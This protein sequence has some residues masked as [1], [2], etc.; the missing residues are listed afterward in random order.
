MSDEYLLQDETHNDADEQEILLDVR[1]LQVHFPIRDGLFRRQVGAIRAVDDVSFAVARGETVALV[2][3]SGAGKTLIGRTIVQLTKPT[4]GEIRFQGRNI[5]QLN[6]AGLRALRRQVQIIFQDPYRSLNPRMQVGRLVGEP[7]EIH[8]IGNT[9]EREMRV[10]ALLQQVG[11]NPYCVGR[12]PFDFSG[13]QRQRV[14]LARALASDPVLLILDE[15]LTRLDPVVHRQMMT[16]LRDLRTANKLTYLVFARDMTYLRDFADWIAVMYAGRIVELCDVAE[17]WQRP[18]HPY[19]QI[20]LSQL[21]ATA[22]LPETSYQHLKLS[23]PEFDPYHTP[24][25]CRF[26]PRCPYATDEC[27]HLDPEYRN[28]GTEKRPHWAACHYAERFQ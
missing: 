12:P 28:L 10:A 3:E 18:L 4:A 15:P 8:N 2:G 11:L 27:R 13:L 16:L 26:H 7:L 19:T 17:M 24:S 6:Q 22:S 5:I 25:G 21:P 1:H 20:L 9:A 23:G 14:N